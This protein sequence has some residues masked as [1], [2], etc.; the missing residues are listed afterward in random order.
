VPGIGNQPLAT[1]PVWAGVGYMHGENKRKRKENGVEWAREK[2]I[3][4]LRGKN[5]KEGKEVWAD[6]WANF[7]EEK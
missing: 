3:G 7:G 4:G 1:A 5:R 6:C 2:K